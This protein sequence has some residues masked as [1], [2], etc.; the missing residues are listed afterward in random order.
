MSSNACCCDEFRL[1]GSFFSCLKND[2]MNGLELIATCSSLLNS[3]TARCTNQTT[4][5]D[6]VCWIQDCPNRPEGRKLIPYYVF[7]ILGFLFFCAFTF[8][9][10]H[11]PK[12]EINEAA[13]HY[14]VD[15]LK[16]GSVGAV[17]AVYLFILASVMEGYKTAL[18]VWGSFY[19]ASH[20][21]VLLQSSA[22]LTEL[23]SEGVDF[24]GDQGLTAV[25][26]KPLEIA[27][28]PI[29][30]IN[31][32]KPETLFPIR[33]STVL[34]TSAPRE[35][36]TPDAVTEK[37]EEKLI[38]DLKP[39]HDEEVT[40]EQ[41]E[42]SISNNAPK[43]K[44]AK[45]KDLALYTAED[46]YLDTNM[47]I[48]RVFVTFACQGSLLIMYGYLIVTGDK[49][50]FTK[51]QTYLYYLL[52]M[53]IQLVKADSITLKERQEYMKCFDRMAYA[54]GVIT[55]QSD[56]VKMVY[57]FYFRMYSGL[58]INFLGMSMLQLLLPFHL[59]QSENAMDFVLNAVAAYFIIELDDYKN[60]VEI[61]KPQE[62]EPPQKLE[63]EDH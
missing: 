63:L 38:T 40:G 42:T 14:I 34:E 48:A 19:M 51:L 30:Q 6:L 55:E 39:E 60:G 47:S 37:H 25:N 13:F 16:G 56:D 18:I 58:T 29:D 61:F 44:K 15:Y 49:P 32:P 22:R 11:K 41:S 35:T 27:M 54:M 4:A 20:L 31:P 3:V 12:R 59:A 8:P 57:E 24:S 5:D 36:N 21:L 45:K 2:E 52:G 33:A 26:T 10:L 62:P 9:L 43:D 1:D 50:D 46:V 28:N 7:L 53:L 17:S 23:A